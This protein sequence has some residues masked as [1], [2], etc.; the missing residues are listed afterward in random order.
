MF[1]KSRWITLR[2]TLNNIVSHLVS[3]NIITTVIQPFV[4]SFG[5]TMIIIT[6]DDT[7]NIQ[8]QIFP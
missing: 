2:I 1:L 8:L 6:S 4:I 7:Q 3:N 5:I